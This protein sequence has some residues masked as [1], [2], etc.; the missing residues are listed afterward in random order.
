M[1]EEILKKIGLPGKVAKVYGVAFE[2]GP[3]TAQQMARKLNIPRPTIHVQ[4]KSLTKLGLMSK[5]EKG[6][7]TY[8]IAESPENLERLIKKRGE[9]IRALALE[10]K[11]NLPRLNKLFLTAEEKPKIRIF[12]GREGLFTMIKDFRQ[13]KFGS[14]EEFVPLDESFKLLPPSDSDFRHK[15]TRKFRKIPMRII[16]TS[17]SGPILKAKRGAVERR[18]VPREKFPHSGS[19]TIYGDKVALMTE[20]DELVGVIID[21]RGIAETIQTLFNLA[22]ES[23]RKTK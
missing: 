21:N 22:W 14:A 9:E 23:L 6:G 13:S 11:K 1:I 16:Y 4:V 3:Q 10:F 19:L 17:N 12:E 20:R 7:K 5:I 15:L 18:F 2:F 8:F